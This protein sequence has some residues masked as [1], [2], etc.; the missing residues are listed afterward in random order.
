[1][2]A[3]HPSQQV[4]IPNRLK[5]VTPKISDYQNRQ[6][7]KIIPNNGTG[8]FLEKVAFHARVPCAGARRQS[9]EK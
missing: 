5:Y 9:S 3:L 8:D 4:A 7:T 6:T 1:M 2:S